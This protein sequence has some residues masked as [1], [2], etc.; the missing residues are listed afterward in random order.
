[1]VAEISAD[2]CDRILSLHFN[3]IGDSAIMWIFHILTFDHTLCITLQTVVT[4]QL[5]DMPSRRLPTCAL[6]NS[7]TGKLA[8]VVA[9]TGQLSD[10][11]THGL[12]I[13]DWSTCA[14]QTRQLA[15]WTSH[16]PDNSRLAVADADGSSTCCF[17]CMI[18]NVDI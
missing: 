7:H 12:D 11:P 6:V 13:S 5:V 2:N 4:V 10:K 8:G 15:D 16:G 1:M 3:T 14:S 17:N 18:V 9:V